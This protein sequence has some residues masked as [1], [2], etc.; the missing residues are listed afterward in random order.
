MKKFKDIR[1]FFRNHPVQSDGDTISNSGAPNT[2]VAP[3]VRQEIIISCPAVPAS[4]LPSAAG[5]STSKDDLGSPET[6]PS[7]PILDFP[8]KKMG[9]RQR[10]FSSK[11]Y[12][13]CPWIEYSV[14]EDK[15]YCFVCRNFCTKNLRA[16]NQKFVTSGYDNWKKI[17]E[18]LQKHRNSLIHKQSTEIHVSFKHS[19]VSGSVHDRIVRQ[20]DT[21]IVERREYLIKLIDIIMCLARQGMPLRGHREDILSRNKGNF[22]ELCDVFAKY[23]ATFKKYLEKTTNYSS[24]QIQNEIITTI[25][26]LTL[27]GI[28]AEVKKCGFYA[29]MADEAR[30][31]KKEQLSVVIRYVNNLEVEERF[32]AFIDCSSAR[33]AQGLATYILE[34]MKKCDLHDLPVVAQSYDGASVMAGKHR[35]LQTIIKETH[36]Q[37]IYIHCLAHRYNILIT[38]LFLAMYLLCKKFPSSCFANSLNN[39]NSRKIGNLIMIILIFF[40]RLNLVVVH[41]CTNISTALGFFNTIEALHTHFSHPGVNSELKKIQESLG[42]K[43]SG[44]TNSLSET[45]WACRF[46]NCKAVLANYDAIK[47]VLEDEVDNRQNKNS[48]EAIGLLNCILKADFVVCLFIFR[49]VLSIINILS[50][51]FQSKDATLGQAV[52]VI[53]STLATLE[54]DRNSMENFQKVWDEIEE[55]SNANEISLEPLRGSKRRRQPN[56]LND[57]IVDT[58]LGKRRNEDNLPSSGSDV[59]TS[60]YWRTSVYLQVLDNIINQFKNRFANLPFAESLDFFIKLDFK[61]SESFINTYK[62]RLLIDID[63]LQ[64]EMAILRSVF[65]NKNLDFN[66]KNLKQEINKDFCP[67]YYKLLQVSIF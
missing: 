8:R 50:K 30:S 61:K 63:L 26:Q 42:I 25:A 23:D 44:G 41:A 29:L 16:Q 4:P 39:K 49:S 53:K 43:S 45:R 20:H 11:Y 58:T 37:A 55:F 64:A 47:T 10:C 22:L 6:G 36:P 34:L 7:R 57:F 32:L 3:Y 35:G 5:T 48:V 18:A 38:L 19:I 67:N 52:D 12:E 2:T 27:S 59:N 1:S 33:H 14:N 15:V 40:Y 66:M 60:E 65:K 31:Y 17:G 56:N 62:D 24:P 46:E 54:E 9:D 13:E 51:Y 21:E 28:A